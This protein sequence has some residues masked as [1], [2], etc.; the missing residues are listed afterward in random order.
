MRWRLELDRS[1]LELRKFSFICSRLQS[2]EE[3]MVKVEA[4]FDV[5]EGEEREKLLEVA[6]HF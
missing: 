6:D 4:G 3:G 5:D 2:R 1:R